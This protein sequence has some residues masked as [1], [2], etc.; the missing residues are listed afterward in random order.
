MAYRTAS[1]PRART[2]LPLLDRI[3]VKT[4]CDASWDDMIGTSAVR[5]CCTCSREVYDLS[6]MHPDEAEAFLAQHAHDGELP[7]ARLYRRAD[8]RVLTSECPAGEDRRRV[9]RAL[10]TLAGGIASLAVAGFAVDLAARPVLGPDEADFVVREAPT[11]SPRDVRTDIAFV[12]MGD[13]ALDDDAY[14][15]NAALRSDEPIFGDREP[16]GEGPAPGLG[17]VR[18][19]YV[20]DDAPKIIEGTLRLVRPPEGS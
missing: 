16:E 4:P 6:A 7:C 12:E 19:R 14:D 10:A 18:R 11:V 8:G 9:R 13:L 17:P 20:R 15:V 5:F 1:D 2:R 3:T